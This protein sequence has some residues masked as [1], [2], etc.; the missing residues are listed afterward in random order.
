MLDGFH[1]FNVG[2]PA[3]ADLARNL[4]QF[5]SRGITVPFPDALIATIAVRNAL[6]L[7]TLDKHFQLM[8]TV[9]PALRLFAAHP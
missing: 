3:W 9:L 7:W 5:R 1:Q 2:D 6:E 4:Y 8:Q